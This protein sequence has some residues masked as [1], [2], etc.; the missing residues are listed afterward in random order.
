[1]IKYSRLKIGGD[2]MANIYLDYAATSR[3]HFDIIEKNLNILKEIYANPSSGHTLGKKNAKLAR[4]SRE[5]IANFINA[6][7]EEII[8]TSGGTESNNT[9]FNHVLSRFNSGEVIISSIEHPS[10]KSSAK[11]LEK[12]GFKIHELD[13]DETGSINID[14]LEEKINENTVL[15][16][17][18][19]A[20]NETGV[21][22]PIKEIS[23]LIV[24]KDILLH[25]DIVQAFGKVEIDVKEL[26]LDFAS[27]SAHKIGSL[28]NFGFLYAKNG[29]VE[30]FIL[31]GGQENGL[32][33]GTSDLLGT[34]ILADCTE[35]TLSSIPKLRELKNYFISKLEQSGIEFEVNG[36]VKNSLPNILNIYFKNI[37]AQR[38][39]TY[40]DAQSIYISGGSACSS[41]NVKGSRIIA[42]MYNIERAAHSVRI[43]VGFDITKD[44]IDEVITKIEKLEKRLIERN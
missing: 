13:V 29:D 5:K 43:S 21:L 15:I 10:V 32:R 42:E 12:Y 44:V 2:V 22:N 24:D 31:G 18:M 40:L 9:V 41:G 39:I 37:E 6:T 7:S 1:M 38:L 4:E 28:N 14:E 19:L 27:V 30:P 8:F 23:E 11:H 16:S 35:E 25:S 17:I 34:L 36:S 26:G 20:N 33:S 3:K